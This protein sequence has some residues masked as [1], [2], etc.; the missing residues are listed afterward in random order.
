MKESFENE[1]AFEYRRCYLTSAFHRLD[2]LLVLYDPSTSTR[3]WNLSRKAKV[4]ITTWHKCL[5]ITYDLTGRCWPIS[6][7]MMRETTSYPS[8]VVLRLN[9][10]FCTYLACLIKQ[11]LSTCCDC[12]DSEESFVFSLCT[13]YPTYVHDAGFPSIEL[14]C[15]WL[16]S[17]WKGT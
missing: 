15:Y 16:D 14:G 2:W 9:G 7:L 1:V 4:W 8:Y 17:K 6:L 12:K 13:F 11:E 3:A 5:Q 10:Q